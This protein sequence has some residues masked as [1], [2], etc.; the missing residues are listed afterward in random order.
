[1]AFSGVMRTAPA[2]LRLASTLLAL[3]Q[4]ALRFLLLGTRSS[5][6]RK[7]QTMF[8]RQQLALDLER[9]AKPRRASNPT[10]FSLV[11]LSRL[12]VW[13]NAGQRILEAAVQS[14]TL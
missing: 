4:D 8:L 9:A 3:A 2:L 12:F 10:R 7:A 14:C 13:Q 6:A 1:M 5:A 11:L